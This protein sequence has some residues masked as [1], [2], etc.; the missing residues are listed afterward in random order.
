M[1]LMQLKVYKPQNNN[2]SVSGKL[3]K[4]KQVMYEQTNSSQVN[5]DNF[6]PSP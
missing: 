4:M 1:T 2:L 3:F 5:E 6:I